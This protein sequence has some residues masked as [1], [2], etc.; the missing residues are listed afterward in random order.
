MPSIMSLE[1]P[2]LT[3]LDHVKSR[4]YADVPKDALRFGYGLGDSFITPIVAPFKAHPW[5][6]AAG[7]IVGLW[8]GAQKR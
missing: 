4:L 1:G 8:Y 7:V 2:R 6:L 3:A 5:W